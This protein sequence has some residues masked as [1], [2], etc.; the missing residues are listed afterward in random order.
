M[1]FIAFDIYNSIVPKVMWIDFAV[2]FCL[3]LEI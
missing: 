2:Y 3:G 1:K